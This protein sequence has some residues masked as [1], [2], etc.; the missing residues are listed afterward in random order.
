MSPSPRTNSSNVQP[1]SSSSSS[2]SSS[3]PSLSHLPSE[4]YPQIAQYLTLFDILPLT[5]T[6]RRIRS[7]LRDHLF[8]ERFL[9]ADAINLRVE[10]VLPMPV[11]GLD[12][13]EFGTSLSRTKVTT[14]S[15]ERGER[16][17][18]V[19]FVHHRNPD[20]SSLHFVGVTLSG[21]VRMWDQGIEGPPVTCTKTPVM[22]LSNDGISEDVF[23]PDDE[24]RRT[25]PLC[26]VANAEKICFWN[27][28]QF[29]VFYQSWSDQYEFAPSPGRPTVRFTIVHQDDAYAGWTAQAQRGRKEWYDQFEKRHMVFR[30][31]LKQDPGR[32]AGLERFFKMDGD[33]KG[34]R[35]EQE[36][37]D[38][39]DM[40]KPPMSGSRPPGST[41][42]IYNPWA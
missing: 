24:H 29:R 31:G 16:E 38:V 23:V 14:D 5:L 21:R 13:F 6:H 22:G 15:G 17:E 39:Q 9:Y 40:E 3:A 8:G 28:K 27:D 7:A 30:Y 32:G 11:S 41:V 20:C 26:S 2:S 12:G 37:E 34:S 33:G 4:L 42:R 25:C 19:Y 35:E 10:V 1:S 18:R 36:K